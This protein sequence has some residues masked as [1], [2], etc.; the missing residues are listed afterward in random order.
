[1]IPS[2]RSQVAPFL[3]VD[4]MDQVNWVSRRGRIV[5]HLET[6][7]PGMCAPGLA[8]QP[9]LR[10]LGEDMLGYTEALGR[11]PW[12]ERLARSHGRWLSIFLCRGDE[13]DRA[14]SR[15][16]RHVV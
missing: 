12:R 4:V 3:A 11:L 7:Q 15:R 13:R 8:I 5:F 14:R 16:A 2:K 6:G 1:M 9:V 10:A